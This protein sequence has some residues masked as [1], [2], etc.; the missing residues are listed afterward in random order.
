MPNPNSREFCGRGDCALRHGQITT[1]EVYVRV[2]DERLR[3]A[4]GIVYSFSC[5]PCCSAGRRSCGAPHPL[6]PC[7]GART[8]DG[9][10]A[11]TSCCVLSGT[12][13]RRQ[14]QRHL[15]RLRQETCDAPL[16]QQSATGSTNH[17][18]SQTELKVP[19]SLAILRGLLGSCHPT[20]S[21]K[22]LY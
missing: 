16:L 7:A 3:Q 5:T 11:S 17:M 22:N 9:C 21:T 4:P 8:S 19:C 20:L 12:T 18:T 15:Q 1:T 14:Q 2:S 10:K 13:T 6:L